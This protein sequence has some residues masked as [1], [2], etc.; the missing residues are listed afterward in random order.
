MAAYCHSYVRT[1]YRPF[2]YLFTNLS[3]LADIRLHIHPSKPQSISMYMD[4]EIRLS[5]YTLF[6]LY[7]QMPGL[8]SE[9]PVEGVYFQSFIR[10]ML[11]IN[12]DILELVSHLRHVAACCAG[13]QSLAGLSPCPITL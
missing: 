2:I 13:W 9:H 12:N 1:L 5:I 6:Q 7:G 10:I 8:L 11:Q 4:M 3:K